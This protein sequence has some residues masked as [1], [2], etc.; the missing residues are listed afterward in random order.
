MEPHEGADGFRRK[1]AAA[2]PGE[3]RH[4]RIVPAADALFL[5]QLQQLALAEQRV[6]EVEPVEF[7]L[8]RGKDAEVLDV[9]AVERLVVG[10]LQGAHG[11][12]D[13]LDGV[14]LA[15]GVVVHGVDAPLVAGAVVRGV[16]DAV[17]DRVAHVEVGRGHVDLGAEHARCRR[18][19]RRPSCA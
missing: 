6:G 4:A 2:D 5:H 12:G 15:V 1:A 17:H 18:G 9:P 11:V 10:E 14:R 7:N 8:L 16:K 19:T 13:V 3:R